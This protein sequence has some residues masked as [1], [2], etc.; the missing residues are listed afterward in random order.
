MEVRC[1]NVNRTDN[2]TISKVLYD[3][4]LFKLGEN[5]LSYGAFVLICMP[6]STI[7]E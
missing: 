5:D 4:I 3:K 1:T 7:L 6:N 2:E